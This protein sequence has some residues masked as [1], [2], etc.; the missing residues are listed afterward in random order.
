MISS[1]KWMKGEGAKVGIVVKQK[2]YILPMHKVD[3]FYQH[4][5]S[6]Q[7]SSWHGRNDKNMNLI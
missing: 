5:V 6:M 2:M 3:W 4:L 7:Y 1:T